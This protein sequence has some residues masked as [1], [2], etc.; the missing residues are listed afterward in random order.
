[1]SR[2]L[3]TIEQ[4]GS[5]IRKNDRCP[6]GLVVPRKQPTTILG[7]AELG[8]RRDPKNRYCQ[9]LVERGRL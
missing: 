2:M 8:L 6:V 9:S 3:F 1:M 7:S 5:P 4:T